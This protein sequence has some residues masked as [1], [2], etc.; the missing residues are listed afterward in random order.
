MIVPQTAF[1]HSLLLEIGTSHV[2]LPDGTLVRTNSSIFFPLS[3]PP[4]LCLHSHRPTSHCF[5]GCASAIARRRLQQRLTLALCSWR[6]ARKSGLVPGSHLFRFHTY[7]LPLTLPCCTIRLFMS[8][9]FVFF[10]SAAPLPYLSP[11]PCQF[12]SPLT[13]FG[14]VAVCSSDHEA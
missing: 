2:H 6:Q 10:F 4:S 12:H 13:L 3:S 5:S 7:T 8:L 9:P 1:V 11:P 14:C